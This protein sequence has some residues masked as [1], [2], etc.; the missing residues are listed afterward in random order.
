MNAAAGRNVDIDFDMMIQ[1]ERANV[2]QALNH[3]SSQKMQICVCVRK[4]PLFE[5]ETQAGEID[6]VT[7]NNPKIVVHEPK[8]KVDG[9]TKFINNNDFAF[10][11][12]FGEYESSNDL[13]KYQIKD[14][15]PRLFDN[16][17]VTLFAYG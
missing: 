17:V 8:F 10:D 4:R 2:N 3:V 11:N 13:Y 6:V 7:C 12:T 5:K 15:L 1:Q 14:L 16:G 9:I